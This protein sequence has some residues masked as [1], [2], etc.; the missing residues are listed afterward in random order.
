MLIYNMIDIGIQKYYNMICLSMY[1]KING[2]NNI[3]IFINVDRACLVKLD[4]ID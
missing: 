3:W 2:K 1:K 4:T